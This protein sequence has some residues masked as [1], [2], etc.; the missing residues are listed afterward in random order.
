[1]KPTIASFDDKAL[2]FVAYQVNNRPVC[3]F[4]GWTGFQSML[5]MVVFERRD[6][7]RERRGLVGIQ[8]G[9]L[10]P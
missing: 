4:M 5:R 8:Q 2:N 10:T 7:V 3:S 1:M 9:L 6:R